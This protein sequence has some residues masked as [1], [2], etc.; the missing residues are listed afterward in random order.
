LRRAGRQAGKRGEQNKQTC[1][2]SQSS[3]ACCQ[4]QK[5]KEKETEQRRGMEMEQS[6]LQR[7]GRGAISNTEE[8]GNKKEGSREEEG[9]GG[10]K[11]EADVEEAVGERECRSPS[12]SSS[13]S[14]HTFRMSTMCD[15]LTLGRNSV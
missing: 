1:T 14:Q 5:K 15:N 4:H 6:C 10:G 3:L 2:G 12:H 9:R 13:S 8:G 11:Q 7:K